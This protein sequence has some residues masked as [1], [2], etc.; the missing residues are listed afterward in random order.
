[1]FLRRLLAS[2]LLSPKGV[3]QL[4]CLRKLATHRLHSFPAFL[5][6]I[7]YLAMLQLCFKAHAV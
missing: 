5:H 7:P 1:M 4:L 3:V 2:R 6:N